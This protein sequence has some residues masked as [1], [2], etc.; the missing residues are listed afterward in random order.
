MAAGVE[1]DHIS[2]SETSGCVREAVT[3]V[4]PADRGTE[5]TENGDSVEE[6]GSR[7]ELATVPSAVTAKGGRERESR[8][9]SERET[10]RFTLHIE[11]W[12][13]CAQ[14]P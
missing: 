10:E 7:E 1:G 2:L 8:A 4:P 14:E 5:A 12:W 13:L 6:V 11:N 3:D 9:E